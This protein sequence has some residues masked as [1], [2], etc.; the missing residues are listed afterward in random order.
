MVSFY[1]SDEVHFITYG[2]SFK[3]HLE[4]FDSYLPVWNCCCLSVEPRSF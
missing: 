1:L 2:F 4:E 3:V